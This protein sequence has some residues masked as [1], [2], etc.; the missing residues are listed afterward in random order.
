M[1]QCDGSEIYPQDRKS[2]PHLVILLSPQLGSS[3]AQRLRPMV[4]SSAPIQQCFASA[5]VRYLTSSSSD[6]SLGE[7]VLRGS[8]LGDEQ[9]GYGL[10]LSSNARPIKPN[11]LTSL[12]F[13]VLFPV[14]SY[15]MIVPFPSIFPK[16]L[17]EKSTLA[18]FRLSTHPKQNSKRR[19]RRQVSSDEFCVE[20]F[21]A[22]AERDTFPHMYFSQLRPFARETVLAAHNA[23]DSRIVSLQT[24]LHYYLFYGFKRNYELVRFQLANR[25]MVS[26]LLAEGVNT[27]DAS[28]AVLLAS[29]TNFPL[30]STAP[31]EETILNHPHDSTIT[32]LVMAFNNV[33]S[34]FVRLRNTLTVWWDRF[35][36]CRGPRDQHVLH[37]WR[38]NCRGN[39]TTTPPPDLV[40]MVSRRSMFEFEQ[41]AIQNDALLEQRVRTEIFPLIP[42][43]SKS[44]FAQIRV[45][46]VRLT[47]R[48]DSYLTGSRILFE[49]FL[50]GECTKGRPVDHALYIEPDARPVKLGWLSAVSSSVVF[51]NPKSWIIGSIF[52]G[53]E[54]LTKWNPPPDWIFH[55]NGNGIYQLKRET[56]PNEKQLGLANF[57]DF[58]F[59]RVR[60]YMISIQGAEGESAMDIDITTYVMSTFD[61]KR[62]EKY[63]LPEQA[64]L[65]EYLQKIEF[66]ALLRNLPRGDDENA[67]KNDVDAVARFVT[68]SRFSNLIV[69]KYKSKWHRSALREEAQLVHGGYC[70]QECQ[71]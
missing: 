31:V 64:R 39:G 28:E 29:T 32:H 53:S 51:P 44:C 27:I 68:N 71:G 69:N 16:M 59:Y 20:E 61:P 50:R 58:Y 54:Q 63:R 66:D 26:R 37:S 10:F 18:I 38:T 46:I 36:P 60:P 62:N 25:V 35:P 4:S 17:N 23:T 14:P 56:R 8:C 19:R 9:V 6:L 13:S 15:W 67:K 21:P 30:P 43:H 49:R 48:T 52:Q 12:A 1:S 22:T 57:H 40:F 34:Q 24:Y 65:D 47:Q 41:E 45:C 33:P 7:I 55:F 42:A 70:G 11:W 3:A 2:R 5:V